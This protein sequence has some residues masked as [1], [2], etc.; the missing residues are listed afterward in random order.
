MLQIPRA[1]YLSGLRR[2]AGLTLLEVVVAVSIAAVA[3]ML[4]YPVFVVGNSMIIANQQ[5]MEAE[6]LAMDRALEIFNTFD[7]S[8]VRS[9]TNLPPIAPPAD[10]LLP[11]NTEIRT[12][13]VP[14]SGAGMPLKWDIEVRVWRDRIGPGGKIVTLT[15]DT[16]YRV[17]RY[18]IGRN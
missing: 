16:V 15:N 3:A 10:S 14:N 12:L 17:T 5:K 2:D 6:G 4:L 11:A 7:F 9:E 13:I 18:N 1:E 8:Q